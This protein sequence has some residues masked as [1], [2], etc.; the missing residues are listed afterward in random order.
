VFAAKGLC[1]AHLLRHDPDQI[2]HEFGAFSAW[3]TVG[4]SG[5]RRS[6]PKALRAAAVQKSKRFDP[7]NLRKIM[8]L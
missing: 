6:F 3:R 8:I 7:K 1:R 5:D 4:G 2:A